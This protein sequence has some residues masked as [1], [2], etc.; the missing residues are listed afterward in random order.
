M[1]SDFGEFAAARSAALFRTAVLLT[2][3]P[4][5]A[6]DLVQATL[7]KAWRRWRRVSRTASPEAY[8]R[9]MLVNAVNDRWRQYARGRELPLDVADRGDG[10]DPFAQTEQRD[11]LMRALL[12]LPLG[13]RTVLVLRYFD[14][15]PDTEIAELMGVSTATV[16]SQAARGLAKLRAAVVADACDEGND[17]TRLEGGAA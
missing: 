16:R 2:G 7:E 13:M 4:G 11:Q 10:A 15:L 6:D 8:V 9:R 12:V 5:S 17:R 14:D 3:D 1:E